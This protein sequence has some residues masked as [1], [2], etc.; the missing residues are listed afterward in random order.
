MRRA[1]SRG[2]EVSSRDFADLGL[3]R[4]AGSSAS[5]RSGRDDK[6]LGLE[7]A[8]FASGHPTLRKS[9][10]DGAPMI[11]AGR[12]FDRGAFALFKMTSPECQ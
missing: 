1:E 4:D 2:G 7:E 12:K 3:E 10:K 9:A 8:V 11:V 6:F 5:L